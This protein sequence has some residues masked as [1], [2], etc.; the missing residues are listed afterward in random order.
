MKS[1]SVKQGEC[2]SSIADENGFFWETIWNHPNNKELR[3][4][5]KDPN[6]LYPG[7]V[8]FIP[9]KRLKEVSEPTTQVHRYRLKNSPAKVKLRVLRDAEPR[10]D[11]PYVL[12]I[13]DV[14]ARRGIVPWNGIVEIPIL[15]SAKK[16]R[17]V[18]GQGDEAEE[19]KLNFGQLDPIETTTGVKARLKN[20]GFE[21]GEVNSDLDEQTVEAI[22]D[23]QFYIN[24]PNPNGTLDKQTL[25]RLALLHD[26]EK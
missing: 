16:G 6:I 9:D 8:V 10:A 15:P 19:Y 23:F 17:L 21:C 3:E 22:T 7:D 5:R 4:R 13:D 26:E 11:E 25:E 24:H 1:Y 2:I 14:E 12:F 20:L 18:V